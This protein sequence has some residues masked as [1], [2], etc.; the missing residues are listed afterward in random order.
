MP[1]KRRP[2]RPRID[3]LPDAAIGL[4]AKQRA[5]AEFYVQLGG[6]SGVG[7]AAARAAGYAENDADSRAAKLL[8]HPGILEYIRHL[9]RQRL[10]AGAALGS[11]VMVE[12][13]ETG[14][15]ADATRL[16]AATAL[17]A[18]AGL[19]PI[20]Q[21]EAHTVVEHT[22]SQSALDLAWARLQSAA[23][24]DLGAPPT[25]DITPKKGTNQ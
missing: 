8:A 4:T 23:G 13:A 17:V 11:A 15:N 14:S 18:H 16:K 3:A 1:S 2:G 9:S 10:H 22:M 7:S 12:I 5:F 21:T 19:A 24:Y 25:I 6:K 20:V